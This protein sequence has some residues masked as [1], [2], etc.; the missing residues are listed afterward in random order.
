MAGTPQNLSPSMLTYLW[1]WYSGEQHS[2][3][4]T[5]PCFASMVYAVISRKVF[6]NQLPGILAILLL[7][8]F[9]VQNLMVWSYYQRHYILES[10]TMDKWSWH[11]SGSFL[12][13]GYLLRGWKVL[14]LTP[15]WRMAPA[16]LNSQHLWQHA[17]DL[18]K[19]MKK[20]GSQIVLF[21]VQELW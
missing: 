19:L 8:L 18:C 9:T 17:Q 14:A 11:W 5:Y 13:T 7:L 15:Y 3:R 20:G 12:S 4:T 21:L 2:R 16:H 10:K 6:H 1:M